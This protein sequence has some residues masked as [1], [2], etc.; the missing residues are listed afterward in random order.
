MHT[1]SVD[2]FMRCGLN[3]DEEDTDAEIDEDDDDEEDSDE[4]AED[5]AR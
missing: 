5:V 2:E 3:S 1:L 4:L